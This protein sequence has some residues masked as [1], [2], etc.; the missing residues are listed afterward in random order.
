MG[1]KNRGVVEEKDPDIDTEKGWSCVLRM[2][3]DSVV[4]FTGR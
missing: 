3:V 4:E 1:I 2:T